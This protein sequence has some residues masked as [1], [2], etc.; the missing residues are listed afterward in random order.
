MKQLAMH[1]SS[2]K[3]MVKFIGEDHQ[4]QSTIFIERWDQIRVFGQF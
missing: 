2:I 4:I 1:L 3:K